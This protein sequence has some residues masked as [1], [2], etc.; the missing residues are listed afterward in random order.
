LETGRKGPTKRPST[1]KEKLSQSGKSKKDPIKIT[2]WLTETPILEKEKKKTGE[3]K[4]RGH[5]KEDRI[6]TVVVSSLAN[7][8]GAKTR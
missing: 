1:T 5:G 2:V 8:R 7:N 4:M 3:R 6:K